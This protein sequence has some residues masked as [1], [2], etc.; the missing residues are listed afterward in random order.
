MLSS[1]SR[2][3]Y[4]TEPPLRLAYYFLAGGRTALGCFAPGYQ[5]T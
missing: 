2:L 4:L 1:G 3:R 5:N